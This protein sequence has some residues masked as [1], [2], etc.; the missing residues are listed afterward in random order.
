MNKSGEQGYESLIKW[1]EEKHPG[2]KSNLYLREVPGLE[3]GLTSSHKL[4][5]GD[6]LLHIPSTC[7]LNPLTLLPNSPI[8]KHLFPQTQ[9]SSSS[10]SKASVSNTSRS[11]SEA[12]RARISLST[13]SS[14]SPSRKLD[15][16][17]LLTLHLA[18]TKD[19]K[20]RYESDWKVYID[21]L[22]QSFRPWHPLTWV[23]KPDLDEDEEDW[24]WW[25]CLYQIGLSESA[26]MKIDDVRERFEKDY[27]ILIEVLKEEDPFKSQNLVKEIGKEEILWAWLNVNTRSISIPLN[28]PGPS[29]RNN[30]TLVPIM[31]FINHSSDPSII[32]PRVKQLA[33]PSR[34]R[35][36]ST[37]KPSTASTDSVFLP[38]PPLTNASANG[39]RLGTANG[40]GIGLR[41]AD[42]HLLPGKIDL[43][44]VCPDRGLDEGEEVF[45]EYGGHSSEMLFAEY[46]FCEIPKTPVPTSSKR[47]LHD[48]TDIKVEGLNDG[49]LTSVTQVNRDGDQKPN[50]E[51]TTGWLTMRYGEVDVTPYIRE[52]WDEQDDEEQ[53]EKKQ[54]LEGIGCWGG[55]TLHASP[56]PPH[57]AH[58]LL[59]TL[60]V[61]HLPST[62]PRLPNVSKGLVTYVSPSNETS[63]M[64]T[65]EDICKGAVKNA[66]KR[67]KVV[68]RLDV[69]V[70]DKLQSDTEKKGILQML[71]AMCQEEQ[72]ICKAVLER[73]EN[74]EEFS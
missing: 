42:Q 48:E 46:G 73:L 36:R 7:M 54:V 29:E 53:E 55:N 37:S 13:S 3:R 14:S 23:V 51:D 17:Q 20:H 64:L 59:M 56:S 50:D 27:E 52:L 47:D 8:P 70:K 62:S 49:S 9:P 34:Q 11:P 4:Q 63:A 31:D 71:K 1:L 72:V 74:G 26:K 45:F 65:L 57:P 21:T 43:R 44:L 35:T 69:D 2:F 28:I 15:T 68:Q 24:K 10:S 22:P 5:A 16:T 61:L 25:N 41:K 39:S 33:A 19:P 30:H 67:S 18:L 40:T 58:S 12:K 32:T 60:R 38:S 66:E 6:T